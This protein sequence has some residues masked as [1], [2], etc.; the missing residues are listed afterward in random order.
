[1]SKSK[2]ST[3]CSLYTFIKEHNKPLFGTLD[4]MCAVGLFRPR[5]PVTFLNPNEKLTQKL[6]DMVES[7]DSEKAFNIL[8]SLFRCI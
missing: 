6:V 8:Q 7:G 4:D 1:M 5:Y 3:F 2:G